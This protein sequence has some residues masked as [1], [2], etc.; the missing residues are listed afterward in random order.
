VSKINKI[1]FEKKDTALEALIREAELIKTLTPPFNVREKDDKSFLYFEITKE[2][3]RVCCWCARGSGRRGRRYHS[4]KTLRPIQ[5]PHR[6]P[7]G[8]K[9][10]KE[11]ISLEYACRPGYRQLNAHALTARSGYAPAHAWA[12]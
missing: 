1:D 9:N 8:V 4:G 12:R 2:E 5:L 10:I 11:D 6:A 3:F 7:R